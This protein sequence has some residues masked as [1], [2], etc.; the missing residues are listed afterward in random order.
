MEHLLIA[1]GVG[2]CIGFCL[3]VLSMRLLDLREPDECSMP[4][5]SHARAGSAWWS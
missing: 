4:T 3:G 5:R 1:G 2:L